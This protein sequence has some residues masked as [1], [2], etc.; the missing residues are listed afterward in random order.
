MSRSNE[1]PLREAI[2]QLLEK[3]RLSSHLNEVRLI[4][5]WEEVVGPVISKHTKNL[6][7]KNKILYVEVDSAAL[8]HELM[9]ERTALQQKLNAMVGD[10]VIEDIVIR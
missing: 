7:I 6:R 2:R 8:G 9:Y 1:I 4:D 5:A 3:Y 10:T